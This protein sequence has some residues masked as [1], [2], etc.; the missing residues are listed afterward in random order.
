[1]NNYPKNITNKIR[2]AQIVKKQFKNDD[3]TII[4]FS[5]LELGLIVAGEKIVLPFN[6]PKKSNA[7]L[8][9]IA[10]SEQKENWL[11]EDEGNM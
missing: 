7:E 1:M 8:L 2:S 6:L 10:A 5:V 9:L 4:D 3:G 11:N